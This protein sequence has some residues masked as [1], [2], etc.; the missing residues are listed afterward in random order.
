MEQEVGQKEWLGHAL[1]NVQTLSP[2]LVDTLMSM[3]RDDER[4]WVE[5][6]RPVPAMLPMHKAD[7][8]SPPPLRP[9]SRARLAP[10]S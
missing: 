10:R 5:E 8:V 4:T 2:L 3:V 1:G 7:E 9:T 6:I